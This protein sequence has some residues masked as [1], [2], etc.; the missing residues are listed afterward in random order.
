[1]DAVISIIISTVMDAVVYICMCL[2]PALLQTKA[3]AVG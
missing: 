1:M 2:Q 3:T